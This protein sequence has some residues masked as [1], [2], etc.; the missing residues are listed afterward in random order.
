M[1]ADILLEA[2]GLERRFGERAALRGLDLELR[3]GEVLGLLGP[4][5]AGKSTTL[6][7][8]SGTLPPDRGSVRIQGVDLFERPRAAKRALGYL[9]EHPPLYP[10]MR[11]QDYLEFCARLHGLGRSAGAATRAAAER[12][13]LSEV[14]S[15]TIGNLSKGYRQ[16]I[17][18]AQAIVHGPAV[19]ILDEPTVGLDPTQ[20]HD[21]RE[22]IRELGGEYAVVLSSHLLPEVQSLCA[23]VVILNRGRAVHAGALAEPG[24][25]LDMLLLCAL[26]P[27]LERLRA[28]EGVRRVE[29]VAPR[30]LRLELDDQAAAERVQQTVL[31]AGWG[32]LEWWPAQDRLEQLFL[33]LTHGEAA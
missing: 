15:R 9:P 1:C 23:R 10:D 2:Q 21:M 27:D 33:S 5:G 7:I 32:L 29:A 26:E 28:L 11:V 8:L 17:G 20:L 3:R 30:R 31:G 24:A 19:L 12:C 25:G 13:G 18:I 4:N 14:L 16:R 6:R 22:L